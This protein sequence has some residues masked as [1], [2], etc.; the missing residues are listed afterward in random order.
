MIVCT[1]LWGI[2]GAYWDTYD[3]I[4][5]SYSF[6]HNQ[7]AIAAVTTEALSTYVPHLTLYIALPSI[8]SLTLEDLLNRFMD[9]F[10]LFR[11]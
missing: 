11:C 1:I 8:S 10:E 3:Y 2:N 5:G 4:T 7:I 6:T 9:T